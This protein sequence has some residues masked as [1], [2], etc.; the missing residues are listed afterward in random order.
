MATTTHPSTN[1]E[2]GN[3]ADDSEEYD[4]EGNDDAIQNIYLHICN[5]EG[6]EFTG[7]TTFHGMSGYILSSYAK[8]ATFMRRYSEAY[9]VEQVSL[10]ICGSPMILDTHEI[11]TIPTFSTLYRKETCLEL[12]TN[13]SRNRLI[14]DIRGDLSSSE[15]YLSISAPAVDSS[16]RIFLRNQH[17]HH[18]FVEASQ[19][20][21]LNTTRA[22]CVADPSDLK[23]IQKAR[24]FLP[25]DKTY[26]VK[27]CERMRIMEW[28]LRERQCVAGDLSSQDEVP[29]CESGSL[30]P[31]GE[32]YKEFLCHPPCNE[33]EWQITSSYSR[34][35]SATKISIE[36]SRTKDV[37][38]EVR[39]MAVTD[40][41]SSIGGGTSL[42]LGCSCV[43][44]MET[45]IFLLKLVLQSIHND[46][47]NGV[48]VKDGD[49]VQSSVE[50]KASNVKLI[51]NTS[52]FDVKEVEDV[53]ADPTS[54][55]SPPRKSIHCARVLKSEEI[56]ENNARKRLYRPHPPS[57]S[58]LKTSNT[59]N[60]LNTHNIERSLK[61]L[62]LSQRLTFDGSMDR[63]R[64][65]RQSAI[66]I[67][68]EKLD[69]YLSE[70]SNTQS[71]YD[72]FSRKHPARVKVRRISSVTSR[73]SATSSHTN[74]H[75][76]EHPRRRSQIY[77]KFMA[78]NDF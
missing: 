2:S 72:D 74:V 67:S 73:G 25:D 3:D 42:F 69:Q 47:Y 66:E 4:D 39:K 36:F 14:I 10:L 31:S 56:D 78:M 11:R 24:Q 57:L 15:V 50:A 7:V 45:F 75:L 23:W 35:R 26:T 8:A 48:N 6:R 59:F 41:L 32:L 33:M 53:I 20:T 29:K 27:L 28:S 64:L 63:R 44:L 21:R 76:V 54:M 52:G 61:N 5:E 65:R 12:N 22:H 71:F 19:I 1:D 30:V 70:P 58:E 16:S 38:I 60:E 17:H 68:D 49:G 43:T 9:S 51:L 34:L 13:T 46:V 62:P 40:V 55:Q 18:I 37:L 77:N